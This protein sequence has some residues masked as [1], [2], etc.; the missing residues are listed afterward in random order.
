MRAGTDFDGGNAK[1]AC[2]EQN[3]NAAGGDAFSKTTDDTACDKDVLHVDTDALADT[4]RK[5]VT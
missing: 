4:R 3:A 5:E 1:A 2:L